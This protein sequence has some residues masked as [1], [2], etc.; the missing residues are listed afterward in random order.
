MRRV[1]T[2]LLLMFAILSCASSSPAQ[3]SG[4]EDRHRAIEALWKGV[5][6]FKAGRLNEAIDFF[7]EAKELDPTLTNARLY[8]GTAY[9]NQYV[10]GDQSAKNLEYARR[11]EHEFRTVLLDDQSN[12]SAIDGLGAILYHIA[13]NPFDAARMEESKTYHERH[14]ALQPKDAEP[15]YWIGVIEWDLAYHVKSELIAEF[16]KSPAEKRPV[17]KELSIELAPKFRDQCRSIVDGGIDNLRKAINRRADYADA[18]AYMSLLYRLKAD[19]ESTSDDRAEYNRLADGF[20]DQVKAIKN[21]QPA[22][23]QPLPSDAPK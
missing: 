6:D 16:D 19:M 21:K 22:R 8:L 3:E 20:V 14:V 18:M 12:I 17:T 9:G 1:R 23:L 2:V 10:A 5:E 13:E 11:A 4:T 7:I 15:Y